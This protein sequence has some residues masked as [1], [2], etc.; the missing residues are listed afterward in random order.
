MNRRR[1]EPDPA[2][3]RAN[4]PAPGEL[5]ALAGGDPVDVARLVADTG[6]GRDHARGV[7]V[8]VFQAAAQIVVVEI[9]ARVH[10][11]A[12]DGVIRPCPTEPAAVR[13]RRV[14]RPPAR[15]DAA[16]RFR[17]TSVPAGPLSLVIEHAGGRDAILVTEWVSVSRDAP[18]RP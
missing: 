1:G 17:I 3:A 11:M 10:W 6:W 18:T 12:L 13:T 8:L 15:V 4:T 9:Q 14:S 7:R 16:G 2:G 5:A